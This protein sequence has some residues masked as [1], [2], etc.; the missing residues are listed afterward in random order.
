MFAGW[1]TSLNII[2]VVLAWR[3]KLAHIPKLI[4]KLTGP[5]SFVLRAL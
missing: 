5:A 2:L 3:I 1:K 4:K